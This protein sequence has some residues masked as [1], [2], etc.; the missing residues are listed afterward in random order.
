VLTVSSTL[1][2]TIAWPQNLAGNSQ[3]FEVFAYG[4]AVKLQ[5]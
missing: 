3:S 1:I 4:T 2:S 5:S